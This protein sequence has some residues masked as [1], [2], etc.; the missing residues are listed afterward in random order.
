MEEEFQKVKSEVE[1]LTDD[2]KKHNIINL[3]DKKIIFGGITSAVFLTLILLR[4]S[5]LYKPSEKEDEEKKFSFTRLV[6]YSIILSTLLC[7]FY[8]FLERRKFLKI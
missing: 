1:K 2:K 5:F 7:I 3:N 8:E 6:L 4:P